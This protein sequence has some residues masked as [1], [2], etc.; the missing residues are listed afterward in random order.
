MPVNVSA[1][2]LVELAAEVAVAV[3]VDVAAGVGVAAGAVA[4]TD[5]VDAMELSGT[6]AKSAVRTPAENSTGERSHGAHGS[7]SAC[8]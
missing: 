2:L 1:A 7:A 6:A 8:I 5:E 3:D 4:V